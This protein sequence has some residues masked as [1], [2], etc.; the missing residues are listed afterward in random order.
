M[1]IKYKEIWSYKEEILDLHF[2]HFDAT[3][4][5]IFC[6]KEL[7]HAE[8]Y[9]EFSL[10]NDGSSKDVIFIGAKDSYDD[11]IEYHIKFCPFCGEKF[12]FDSVGKFEQIIKKVKRPEQFDNK[13]E[14]KRINEDS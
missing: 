5:Q 10:T 12:V 6:C 2:S 4:E 9:L 11:T 1:I 7:S 14:L 13:I 8:P 3:D